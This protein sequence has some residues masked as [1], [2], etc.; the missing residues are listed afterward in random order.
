MGDGMAQA[1]REYVESMIRDMH[2][3]A[4]E[5]IRKAHETDLELPLSMIFAQ[6]EQLLETIKKEG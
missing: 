6:L 4:S 3:T 2:E 1:D 5:A